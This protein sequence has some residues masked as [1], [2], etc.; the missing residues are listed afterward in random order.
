MTPAAPDPPAERWCPLLIPLV[1]GP[2]VK[3]PS[4]WAKIPPAVR[5]KRALKFA[6]RECGLRCDL[7][8]ADVPADMWEVELVEEPL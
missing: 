7:V 6:L 8:T 5:V 2:D 1:E 3:R 4:E